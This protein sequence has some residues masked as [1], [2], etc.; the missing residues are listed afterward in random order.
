LVLVASAALGVPIFVFY[1]LVSFSGDLIWWLDT[2]LSRML[3]PSGL[4]LAVWAA[5]QWI[6]PR[7]V[8]ETIAEVG[9]IDP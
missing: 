5:S 6:F 7:N 8:A 2:G 3:L 4:L 1:Y 9:P